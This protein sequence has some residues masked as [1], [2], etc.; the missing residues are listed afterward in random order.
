MPKV[1]DGIIGPEF[2]L[3]TLETLRFRV[4]GCLPLIEPSQFRLYL[5]I[6]YK[7]IYLKLMRSMYGGSAKVNFEIPVDE[8]ILFEKIKRPCLEI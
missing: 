1:F 5:Q 4:R 3:G 8:I 2:K 6:V 7:E